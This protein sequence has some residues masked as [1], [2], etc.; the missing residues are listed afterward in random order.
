MGHRSALCWNYLGLFRDYGLD[1]IFFRYKTFS[2]FRI[3]F[4]ASVWKRI[5]WSQNF[6]LF[7]SFRQLLFLFISIGCPWNVKMFWDFTKFFFKQMLTISAFYLEK[8]WAKPR[9]NWLQY[10]NNSF[11]YWPI[12]SDGFCK[13]H[14]FSLDIPTVGPWPSARVCSRSQGRYDREFLR[15][16]SNV[17]VQFWA[18]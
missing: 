2:F 7:S 10:Q 11:V 3:K 17:D 12:F 6:N 15:P 14:I 9:F 5:L 4:S 1:H 16:I 13:N 18:I 8:N